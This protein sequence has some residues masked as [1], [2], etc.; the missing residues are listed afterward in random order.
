MADRRIEK[1]KK[2]I[3]DT[4]K[5]IGKSIDA[6]LRTDDGKAVWAWLFHA[7]GYNRSSL[8]ISRV[9]GD[10]A[11]LS[12]EAAAAQRDIY[13]E[14]RGLASPG[15][16]AEAEELAEMPAP[17]IEEVKPEEERKK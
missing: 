4:G 5:S 14:L 8:R 1:T 7:C 16:R 13:V 2:T 12:I 17:K 3:P 11:P 10:L 9:T 15:L 6:V